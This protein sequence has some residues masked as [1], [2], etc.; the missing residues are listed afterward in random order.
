MASKRSRG[1][2]R[3]KL[4]VS[5]S[6]T[7]GTSFIFLYY[8]QQNLPPLADHTLKSSQA[9]RKYINFTFL[10]NNPSTRVVC[11]YTFFILHLFLHSL[12]LLSGQTCSSQQAFATRRCRSGQA[13]RGIKI[14]PGRVCVTPL[15]TSFISYPIKLTF[16]RNTGSA[17]QNKTL[18]KTA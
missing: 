12:P 16:I 8:G 17:Q 9:S 2:R 18:G 6:Q 10:C 3:K 13:L 14:K 15:L 7:I 4:F 11:A 5:I 1:T